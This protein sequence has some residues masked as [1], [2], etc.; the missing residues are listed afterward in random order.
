MA[1]DRFG[2]RIILLNKEKVRPS[3]NAKSDEFLR[4][5]VALNVLS[6]WKCRE[7]VSRTTGAT[8][9]GNRHSLVA[10]LP[11]VSLLIKHMAGDSIFEEKLGRCGAQNGNG[12]L[13]SVFV[14]PFTEGT[15]CL[16]TGIPISRYVYEARGNW[17]NYE[18]SPAPVTADN[19][20][21]NNDAGN[22]DLGGLPNDN[23]NELY[24]VYD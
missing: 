5:V 4:E 2:E 11:D 10:K 6:L 9:H 21:D 24:G 19:E 14:D 15:A 17:D 1:D 22:K 20:T 12:N 23:P 13:P 7:A 8:S 3:A 18:M 16:S